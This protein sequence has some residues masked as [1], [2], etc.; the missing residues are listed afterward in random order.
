MPLT[1]PSTPATYFPFIMNIARSFCFSSYI[2]TP[3]LSNIL[4][5]L[6]SLSF[7]SLFFDSTFN[8]RFSFTRSFVFT[9]SR[10]I[11]KPPYTQHF[12]YFTPRPLIQPVEVITQPKHFFRRQTNTPV[13]AKE[14]H[15]HIDNAFRNTLCCCGCCRCSFSLRSNLHRL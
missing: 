8:V 3:L 6:I 7:S 13:Y 5:S 9:D 2:Q 1:P 4:T 10:H 14:T 12:D 15:K 11:N